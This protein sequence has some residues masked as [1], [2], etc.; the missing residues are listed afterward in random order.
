MANKDANMKLTSVKY[1]ILNNEN[2]RTFYNKWKFKTMA[3]IWKQGWDSLFTNPA[4]TIP[5]KE[6]VNKM[7]AMEAQKAL[8]KANLEAYD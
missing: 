5:T 8:Y 2:A 3:I 1:Y 4:P 6:D 7:S